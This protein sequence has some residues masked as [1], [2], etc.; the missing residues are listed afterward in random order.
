MK[1][2]KPLLPIHEGLFR[3]DCRLCQEKSSP[4]IIHHV[5]IFFDNQLREFLSALHRT[6]R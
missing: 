4:L 6:D 5:Q 3:N 2:P 1:L